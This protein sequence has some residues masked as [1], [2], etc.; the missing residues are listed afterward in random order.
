MTISIFYEYEKY[1]CKVCN[2]Y[3]PQVGD[4][5]NGIAPNRLRRPPKIGFAPS[6]A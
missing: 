2:E 4:P 1:V 3:D 5:E 6:A